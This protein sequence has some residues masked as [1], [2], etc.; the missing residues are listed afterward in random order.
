MLGMLE[1]INIIII[2]N[3]LQLIERHSQIHCYKKNVNVV[4]ITAN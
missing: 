1:W 3:A 4:V 2:V